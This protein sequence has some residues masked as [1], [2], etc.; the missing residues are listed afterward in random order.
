MDDEAK[1]EIRECVRTGFY[2]QEEVVTQFCE[3]RYE[4]GELDEKEVKEMVAREIAALREEQQSWPTETDCD[5]LSQVL[6]A[7]T[8]KGVISLENAG[9]TQSDGYDDVRDAYDEAEDK[10]AISGYCTYHG[11]DLERAMRGG[12]LYL[13]FGPIDPQKEETEGPRVGRIIVEELERRGF[14]V[15]W[16][17][18][19]KERIL[20]SEI[21]WKKR[22]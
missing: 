5:R 3:E 14:K 6:E 12:G 4:P 19:F 9:Y 22:I 8:K 21:D 15:K 10:K 2:S 1:G 17:G 13:A 7:L 20:I 16:D 18:T 11:Q